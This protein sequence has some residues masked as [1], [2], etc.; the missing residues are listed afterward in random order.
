MEF[1][2][3]GVSCDTIAAGPGNRLQ[4]TVTSIVEEQMMAD[5]EID[6]ELSETEGAIADADRKCPMR[7]QT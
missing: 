4:E 1:V 6:K 3:L 2:E 5:G 7:P